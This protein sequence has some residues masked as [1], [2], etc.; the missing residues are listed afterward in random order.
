MTMTN[1]SL[2]LSLHCIE[3]IEVAI[4]AKSP[5]TSVNMSADKVLR[6]K[7]AAKQPTKIP[8]LGAVVNRSSFQDTLGL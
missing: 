4:D 8:V 6:S 7:G 2:R 1:D 5:T 3:S